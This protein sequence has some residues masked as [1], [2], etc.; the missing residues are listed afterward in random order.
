MDRSLAYE[1][2]SDNGKWTTIFHTYNA[3]NSGMFFCVDNAGYH[4]CYP[5]YRIKRRN[6]STYL[7]LVTL[8]GEGE[9]LMDGKTYSLTP[10]SVMFIDCVPPHEYY[11][12]SSQHWC[13]AWIHFL[14]ANA[15]EI[16]R[17]LS[18]QL[19][20]VIRLPAGTAEHLADEI[21]R[22]VR[23]KQEEDMQFDIKASGILSGALHNILLHSSYALSSGAE[24]AQPSI[25]SAVEFIK[26]SYSQEISLDDMAAAA[27][28]SKYYFTKMFK[29]IT[30]YTPY[31]YLIKY[32]ID[33]AK[34]LL[35]YSSDNVSQ[36][37]QAV[38]FRNVNSFI[39]S[40]KSFENTTPHQ[41]RKTCVPTSS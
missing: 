19:G 10:Q 1:A 20:P 11:P 26:Q 27:H 36:I 37:A 16:Y 18:G 41:F 31:E 14:G 33:K 34:F 29:S 15:G 22:I 30:G 2:S 39:A 24:Q 4:L 40:F 17:H 21:I 23:L 5:R 6:Y 28:L 25:A 13:F 8:R 38:G 9:L 3:E 35:C 7:L 32:R 12:V